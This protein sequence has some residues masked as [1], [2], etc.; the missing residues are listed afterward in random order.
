MV[1]TGN[2]WV[3]KY[4]NI[5]LRWIEQDSIGLNGNLLSLLSWC[6]LFSEEMHHWG[7]QKWNLIAKWETVRWSC[8]WLNNTGG[9]WGMG[10]LSPHKPQKHTVVNSRI[11]RIFTRNRWYQWYPKGSKVRGVKIGCATWKLMS[12]LAPEHKKR[13]RFSSDL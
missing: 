10:G 5:Y 7:V 12:S 4:D 1:W 3:I 8:R 11:S 6:W 2:C 9:V 13:V